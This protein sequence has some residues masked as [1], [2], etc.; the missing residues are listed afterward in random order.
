MVLMVL[1]AIKEDGIRRFGRD[2]LSRCKREREMCYIKI[3][4]WPLGADNIILLILKHIPVPRFPIHKIN[5]RLIRLLHTALLNPW[6]NFLVRGKLQHL[7]DF[8]WRA[9]S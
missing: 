6:L 1:Q 8:G 5:H 7:R 3:M 2:L 9:D 4:L